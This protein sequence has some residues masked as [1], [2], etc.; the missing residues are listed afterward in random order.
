VHGECGRTATAKD[1]KAEF[2]AL[3]YCTST[4]EYSGAQG[5]SSSWARIER[6]RRSN[7]SCWIGALGHRLEGVFVSPAPEGRATKARPLQGW[8]DRRHLPS[9]TTKW[10][11]ME[12]RPHEAVELCEG[13]PGKAHSLP[14][15]GQPRPER[16]V[17]TSAIIRGFPN[18]KEPGRRA[19]WMGGR[20]EGVSD[21]EPVLTGSDIVWVDLARHRVRCGRALDGK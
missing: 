2:R 19:G 20:H 21:E 3:R 17:G 5:H 11:G 15:C 1:I 13:A 16:K 6:D 4:G 7:D 12:A 9:S 10:P 8:A 14:V 18:Q